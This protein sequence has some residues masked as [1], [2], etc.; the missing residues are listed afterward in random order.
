MKDSEID[1]VKP[2]NII[3]ED[4]CKNIINKD[5]KKDCIEAIRNLDK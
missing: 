4:L 3:A 2:P 1:V 5:A